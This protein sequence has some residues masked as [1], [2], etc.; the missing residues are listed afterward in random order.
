[1]DV[2]A[3]YYPV[4]EIFSVNIMSNLGYTYVETDCSDLEDVR[5]NE[6]I[7]T[8]QT[9]ACWDIIVR[10]FCFRKKGYTKVS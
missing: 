2:D 10:I 4:D 3:C 1:M 9:V 6:P 7:A 8:Y 5:L